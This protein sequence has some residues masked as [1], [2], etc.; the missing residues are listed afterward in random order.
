MEHIVNSLIS[1]LKEVS[2]SE[3]IIFSL[4]FG[5]GLIIL[6]S[7]IPIL[8]LALFI[9]LN[10]IL[11]GNIGGFILSWI[12]TICGCLISYSICK[13]SLSN[14][15]YKH[16]KNHPKTKDFVLKVKNISFTKLVIIMAIPFTPAFSINIGAGISK[17]NFK[18]FFS[19]LVISKLSIVY[20]WGF[21]GTTLIESL[22]DIGVLIKLAVIMIIVFI[23][24]KIILKKFDFD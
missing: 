9:A 13:Y 6:E 14:K 7:I 10:I 18:K 12:A 21:V 16:L 4:L 19:A 17:M 3:P 20:F 24:S 22:T 1:S 5:F 11:F 23:L 2:T 15:L 8:P